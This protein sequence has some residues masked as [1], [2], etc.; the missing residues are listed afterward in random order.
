MRPYPAAKVMAGS[1]TAR[2]VA[3]ALVVLSVVAVAAAAP[4]GR[5][6]RWQ[7]G[8][9]RTGP[10]APFVLPSGQTE[11]SSEVT[12]AQ[13]GG[14]VEPLP[15]AEGVAEL[16][17]AADTPP[18]VLVDADGH[19][20]SVA[21]PPGRALRPVPGAPANADAPTTAAAFVNRYGQAFGLRPGQ[22]VKRSRVDALGDGDRAVRFQHEIGGVPVLGGD[23][24]VTVDDAGR[25]LSASGETPVGTPTTTSARISA[26]QAGATAV[27]AA[28]QRLGLD[29]AALAVG[30]AKLWLYEPR[31]IGAPGPDQLRPTW[32]VN[33]RHSSG[34][35]A[36]TALI[37]ATDGTAVLVYSEHKT[38]K[39]RRV[40]D[41][42]NASVDTDN[43]ST[44]V[45]SD[46]AGGPAVRRAEGVPAYSVTDV[47][48]AYDLLGVTYD[49]YKNNFGRDSIDGRGMQMRAT[50]RVCDFRFQCPLRNAFWDGTQVV[51]GQGFAG[52]DDVVAHEITHGVTD[53]TSELLYVYQ[54]GAIN[55]ALSDIIGELVDQGRGSDNDSQWDVGE[56][57]PIGAIRK[58]SDPG[59]FGDP[60]RYGDQN[61]DFDPSFA[62]NGGV[63]SNSGVANK[64][65][66]LIAVGGPFNFRFI[67]PIGDAPA[68]ARA[69]SAQLW[70]RVMHL[71]T[72]GANYRD[73][74][75]AL[76]AACGQLLG[77]TGEGRFSAFTAA[78]CAQVEE[79]VAA[80]DMDLAQDAF[81]AGPAEAMMCPAEGQPIVNVFADGFERGLGKW[82]R[83]SNHYWQAVPSADIPYRYAAERKSSLNGWTDSAAPST[84]TA[85]ILEP[86]TIPGG[87]PTFLWFAHSLIFG[88]GTGGIQ[89][90]VDRG[91]GAGWENLTPPTT[92]VPFSTG[93]RLTSRTAGF[94][95][96]RFDLSGFAGQTI[97][98]GFR[99]IRPGAGSIV[100]WY[101]DDLHI[102][103]CSENVG[104]VRDVYGALSEDRESAQI[105]WKAPLYEGPEA[106]YVYDV[107]VRPAIANPPGPIP[108]GTTTVNLTGLDPD[109]TYTVAVRAVNASDNQPG[110]GRVIT[111]RSNPWID[112][113]RAIVDPTTGRVRFPCIRPG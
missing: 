105:L 77:Y 9:L 11:Q 97:K 96:T 50:V 34:G 45:C 109:T 30:E 106:A 91:L 39:D 70:Y 46:A 95:A 74:G 17:K 33:L 87:S 76:G 10:T 108:M 80:T 15:A 66:Y 59:W 25:V 18:A 41:L 67:T 28:V 22:Q 89:P 44:Y 107:T 113:S 61:W 36:A 53:F 86:V 72:S 37:D 104:Q 85:G 99:V 71:L 90:L 84:T 58:M 4:S 57:L 3:G 24:I 65:A 21:A 42:A 64:A 7:D 14:D 1:T 5:A 112:C 16:R 101:L 102:Y 51:F 13:T 19:L 31:M 12:A 73:L 54:S 98:I 94:G 6:A 92:G 93:G 60:G 100:D 62:D 40:C 49:F 47:N 20:R 69:K 56:S 88:T 110:V 81:G 29:A 75:A 103:Q 111:L 78:N 38:A 79:A 27:D 52:A 48:M 82:T 63:H 43:L 26:A 23:L 68:D 8:S 32:I 2:V 83:T 35:R 55:E